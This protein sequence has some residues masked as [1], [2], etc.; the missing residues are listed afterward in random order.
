MASTATT[1]ELSGVLA[2]L[3]DT[4]GEFRAESE[5]IEAQFLDL[6]EEIADHRLEAAD[7]SLDEPPV[8]AG[9]AAEKA[10]KPRPHAGRTSG[11]I[12]RQASPAL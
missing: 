7:V 3:S 2:S 5:E 6:M 4:F 10:G 8:F 9:V 1:S 11:R 12:L